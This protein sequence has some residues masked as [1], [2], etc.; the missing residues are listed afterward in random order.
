MAGYRFICRSYFG[1][2][3]APRDKLQ[4][5]FGRIL[6]AIGALQFGY[7]MTEVFDGDY[8]RTCSTLSFVY[9]IGLVI[10]W[11]VPETKGQPLPD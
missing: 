9:L 6:A 8:V 1:R 10:I 4:L 11:F 2:R 5:Q 7:L 3:S